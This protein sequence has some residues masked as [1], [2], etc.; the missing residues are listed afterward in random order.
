LKIELEWIAEGAPDPPAHRA[1]PAGWLAAGVFAAAAAVTLIVHL[2]ETPAPQPVVRFE[3][4]T[5]PGRRL[6]AGD[7][8]S[9]SPDGKRIV[10]SA[11]RRLFVRS[12]DSSAIQEV[13]G[14]DGGVLPSW[15]PDGRSVAYEA[16]WK[17]MKV[18]LT[19]GP[20]VFLRDVFGAPG[21][22]WNR[23]GT[24]VFPANPKSPLMRMPEGGGTPVPV[25]TLDQTKGEIAHA[26]PSFLPDGRHFLFTIYATTPANGGVYVGSLDSPQT[27]RLL[28]EQTNAQ[29]TEPGYILFGQGGNLVAQPFDAGPLRPTGD[30]FPVVEGLFQAGPL[31]FDSFSA[32]AGVLVYGQRG[33]GGTKRLRLADRTGNRLADVGP[34]A[35]Y[36]SASLSPDSHAVATALP[37]DPYSDIW[38]FDLLR[39][40]G[41][42]L[43]LGGANHSQPVWSPDGKEIAFVVED[44]ARWTV[45]RLPAN[46]TGK[47]ERL[48]QLDRNTGLSQWTDDGRSLILAPFGS[49]KPAE[50]WAAGLQD[51]AHPFPVLTG[52]F[53]TREAGVSR[54]GKWIAYTS[55]ATGRNEVY[56]QD[57]P[58]KAVKRQISTAGGQSPK[59][60]NDGR[61]LFYVEGSRMMSVDVKAT[62]AGFEAGL[63]KLLFENPRNEILTFDAS[64]DGRTFLL[65]VPNEESGPVQTFHVVLNWP[66]LRSVQ[67]Q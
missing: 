58:P 49:G 22:A 60:Q 39:R 19:G 29:Y 23:D 41:S 40:N 31:S 67:S 38:V 9:V 5:P 26:W 61:E 14:A 36:W 65:I 45:Y 55:N 37:G 27:S 28:P 25:T 48:V 59:W 63:P 6:E 56:V 57:F 32:S 44:P 35:D 24:I 16:F 47:Q 62:A 1:S 4:S 64:P 53:D 20:P 7:K 21:R 30:S 2:R 33:A 50:I 11:G 17:L 12:L 8:A 54:D 43:T 3:L 18:G 51:L 46:G 34:P 66:Q 15:S 52:P 42:R 10:F 13:P